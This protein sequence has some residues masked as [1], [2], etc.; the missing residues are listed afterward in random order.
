MDPIDKAIVSSSP[1]PVMAQVP[2]VIGST[3]RPAMLLIPDDVTDREVMELAAWLLNGL[4]GHIAAN[5][6]A[7]GGLIVARGRLDQ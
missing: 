6:K 1:D 7:S 5:R 4:R 3:G 2:I